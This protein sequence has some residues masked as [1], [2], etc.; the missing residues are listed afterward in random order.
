MPSGSHGGGGGGHFGGFSSSGGSHFSGGSS[1]GSGFRGGSN[2]GPRTL[3]FFGHR[4]IVGG[5]VASVLSTLVASFVVLLIFIIVSSV[6]IGDN[7]NKLAKIQADYNYYQAMIVNAENDNNL[8]KTAVVTDRFYNESAKKWYYTYRIKDTIVDGYTFS[9]YDDTEIMHYGIGKEISV[10][11][12]RIPVTLSTDSIPMDYKNT[13][14][15]QDGEYVEIQRSGGFLT[16]ILVVLAMIE[17]AIVAT[18]VMTI[19]KKVKK[20]NEQ[21]KVPETSLP[22]LTGHDEINK[23]YKCSY[24]GSRL[25]LE[26]EKCPNCGASLDSMK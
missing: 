3:V 26:D 11:V 6:A 13:T 15:Q 2:Q 19:I 18:F 10:A 17:L 8:I 20:V 1:G 14:L 23:K 9:L 22:P 25:K 21:E 7:N 5:G 24:C 16:I 4:Y 12:D